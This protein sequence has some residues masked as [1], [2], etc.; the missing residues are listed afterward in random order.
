MCGIVGAISQ[1]AIEPKIVEQMRDRLAHR[2]PDHAGLWRSRNGQVCLGHRRLSIIDL[3]HR[4]NQPMSSHDDRFQVTLNGEIYNYRSLRTRLGREGVQFRTESDTEVLIEAY[5]FWGEDSLNLLSG[6]Y[7]F[8][9]WDA[10]ARRLFCARDR[11]GE[12]PF[13]YAFKAG[14]FLFASEIKALLEWPQFPRRL[15]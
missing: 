13:Y 14:T 9:I 1:S 12:K 8:A 6:M 7:A 11:A 2:G 4:S 3:D 5:R 15:D 10:Q